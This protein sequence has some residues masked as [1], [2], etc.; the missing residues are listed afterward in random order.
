MKSM[1]MM[2]RAQRGFTLI[3]LMIVVAIIGILAAIAIPAYQDYITRAKWGDNLTSTQPL[4]LAIAECMQ[5]NAGDGTNCE[6]ALQLNLNGLPQAK[7]STGAMTVDGNASAV[8]ITYVGT[9]EVGGYRYH[10]TGSYD[11]SGTKLEW[12]ATS[13]TDDIP[14][15]IIKGNGR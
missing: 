1:E 11:A 2:K 13:G 8:T 6:T 4:K 7:Y 3:E 15:K 10:A 5:N 9:T 14:T 12:L